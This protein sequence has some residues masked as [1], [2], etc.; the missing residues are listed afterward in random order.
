M[1]IS[2]YLF[3]YDYLG[4][5]IGTAWRENHKQTTGGEATEAAVNI[6]DTMA[7]EWS[8]GFVHLLYNTIHGRCWRCNADEVTIENGTYICSECFKKEQQK[9]K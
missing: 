7:L 9:E 1:D 4:A 5:L 3:D 8:R 6:L 2:R